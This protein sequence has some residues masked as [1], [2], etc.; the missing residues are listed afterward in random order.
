V[1]QQVRKDRYEY[2]STSIRNV[3][4]S[5]ARA[6][7]TANIWQNWNF[8]EAG[9]SVL[10]STETACKSTETACKSSETVAVEKRQMMNKAAQF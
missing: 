3:P 5:T 2:D 1:T 4:P 7:Y 8:V 6:R 9:Q 10:R